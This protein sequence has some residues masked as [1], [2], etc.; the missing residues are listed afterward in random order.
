MKNTI[1]YLF[2]FMITAGSLYLAAVQSHH[3]HFS[4]LQAWIAVAVCAQM[5]AHMQSQDV[6]INRL[7]DRVK[8]LEN[9]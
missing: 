1:F 2:C 7:I 3:K 9:K 4:S 5:V 6:W 8:K